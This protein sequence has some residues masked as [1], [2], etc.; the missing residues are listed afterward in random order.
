MS[1][2]R[3]C[4]T[5]LDIWPYSTVFLQRQK[6]D[7]QIFR[8]KV[9][10]RISIMEKCFQRIGILIHALSWRQQKTPLFVFI[11]EILWQTFWCNNW[12]SIF[13]VVKILR[14]W[15]VNSRSGIDIGQK[16]NVKLKV[17]CRCFLNWVSRTVA[18]A[19]NHT[20]KI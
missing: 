9:C 3:T 16:I 8:Q 10:Q 17:F 13:D 20:P 4:N 19:N 14:Y 15:L 1:I 12:W 5:K 2:F 6:P 18:Q 11:T 7:R